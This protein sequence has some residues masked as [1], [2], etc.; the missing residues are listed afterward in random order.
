M[1]IRPIFIVDNEKSM[2]IEEQVNFTWYSGFSVSQKQKSILS[3][4]EEFLKAH[5]GSKILEVSTK[6]NTE[7]GKMLSAFNLKIRTVKTNIEVYVESAYQSSKIFQNGGPYTDIIYMNPREAKKDI[8]LKTSGKLIGFKFIGREFEKEPKSLFY[9]WLYI[10]SL[11]QHE[12][13]VRKVIEF[14]A[15]SDIEFNPNKSVSCQAKALALFVTIY[16]QNKDFDFNNVT[17]FKK[18]YKNYEQMSL[19]D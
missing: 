16:R 18:L 7:L 4:H 12:D 10:N 17:D 5:I 15:F 14:D 13:L 2:F 9:D 19:L 3:L 1:A 8:R 6:S 11:L